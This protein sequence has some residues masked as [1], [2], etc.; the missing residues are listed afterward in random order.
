MSRDRRH[1]LPE[2]NPLL[3]SALIFIKRGTMW[4]EVAVQMQTILYKQQQQQQH[5]QQQKK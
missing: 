4:N 5:Q 3:N 2:L 1:F